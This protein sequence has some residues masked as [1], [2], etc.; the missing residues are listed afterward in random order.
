MKTRASVSRRVARRVRRVVLGL[1]PFR[2]EV[3]LRVL[4]VQ[5]QALTKR[6]E[7][8]DT[9]E[10]RASEQLARECAQAIEHL[11]HENVRLRRDLDSVL[12]G[13]PAAP[14]VGG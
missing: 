5:I 7:S 11:L 1:D 2:T 9:A 12:H 3:R 4:E 14:E 8:L 10:R 6:V 13:E